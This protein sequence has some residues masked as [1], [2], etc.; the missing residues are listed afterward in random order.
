MNFQ[1]KLKDGSIQNLSF[2]VYF[3]S[4]VGKLLDCNGI[5]ETF[6]K[7]IGKVEAIGEGRVTGGMLDDFD[8]R[9]AVVAAGAEAYGFANGDFTK[10]SLIDGYQVMNQIEDSLKNPIWA[11]MYIEVCKALIPDK[12]PEEKKTPAKKKAASKK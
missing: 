9:A 10:K 5:Q 3:L 4:A 1:V 7:V 12:L 11:Q 8:I 6:T 2:S